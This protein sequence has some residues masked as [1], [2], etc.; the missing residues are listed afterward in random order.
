MKKILLLFLFLFIGC[1]DDNEESPL[2]GVWEM[3]EMSGGLFMR[4]NKTQKIYFGSTEGE[5]KATTHINEK[6]NDTFSLT[7]FNFDKNQDGTFISAINTYDE[8]IQY[9]ALYTISDYVGSLDQYDNS[10]FY[11]YSEDG[12]YEY[13]GRKFD[14]VASDKS[15]QVSSDTVYRELFINN[16]IIIDSTRY[17]VLNGEIKKVASTINANENYLMEDQIFFPEKITLTLDEG[18]TGKIR[19]SMGNET[20]ESE[21]E[22][23]TTD[24]TFQWN[25][26]YEDGPF[27][28][29]DCR[30]E[31]PIFKYT[32]N[33]NSLVLFLYQDQCAILDDFISCDEMM[34]LQ[35]GIEMATLDALWI[36]INV[37]FSKIENKVF[38]KMV[39]K[40]N[41]QNK[42]GKQFSLIE[43]LKE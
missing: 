21:I 34:N 17:T 19:E 24:S 30:A 2:V 29:P 15:F 10:Q 39:A 6:K 8:N 35:Y 40:N 32:L 31:G 22:W 16:N 41:N 4:V 13:K 9:N 27:G 1:E 33:E 5:I 25:Y 18:G 14:Y 12:N 37:T 23:V 36:E 7:E 26:C 43:G 3:N 11:I 38:K 20:I 42:K 28:Q